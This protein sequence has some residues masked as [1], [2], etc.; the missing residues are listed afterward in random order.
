MRKI[1]YY[2]GKLKRALMKIFSIKR[3]KKFG[4]QIAFLDFI[5]FMCHRSNSKFQLAIVRA[6]DRNVQKYIYKNY[7]NILKKYREESL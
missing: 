3:I 5:S 4:I 7:D 1:R 6:K 2:F